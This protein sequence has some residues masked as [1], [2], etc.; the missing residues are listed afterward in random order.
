MIWIHPDNIESGGK[1]VFP[2]YWNLQ[3]PLWVIWYHGKVRYPPHCRSFSWFYE[4]I[5]RKWRHFR[6]PIWWKRTISVISSHSEE[7]VANFNIVNFN[8]SAEEFLPDKKA[9]TD[10]N[11]LAINLKF[12]HI[13]RLIALKLRPGQSKMR[14]HKKIH[15]TQKGLLRILIMRN[16][17]LPPLSILSG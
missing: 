2:Q 17:H 1:W 15:P 12:T 3:Q 4:F 8:K 13:F 11:L 9:H 7:P 5:L 14:K 6:I 10:L 16:P